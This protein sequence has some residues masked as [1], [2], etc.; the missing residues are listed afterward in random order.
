[1]AEPL[2]GGILHLLPPKEEIMRRAWLGVEMLARRTAK[3]QVLNEAA[4]R[5]GTSVPA[6]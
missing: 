6:V 5:R 2:G 4:P 3:V 1:M